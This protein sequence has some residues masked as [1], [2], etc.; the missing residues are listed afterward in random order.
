MGHE[1]SWSFWSHG[2][3]LTVFFFFTVTFFWQS[4]NRARTASQKRHRVNSVENHVRHVMNQVST[5]VVL[6]DGMPASCGTFFF[7]IV[8]EQWGCQRRKKKRTMPTWWYAD[9]KFGPGEAMLPRVSRNA[10]R[11]SSSFKES[12]RWLC[13]VGSE[14][15]APVQSLSKSN[16]FCLSGI[17]N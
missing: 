6:K 7:P 17:P 14:S 10:S 9:V 12:N 16:D 8:L 13:W 1:S 15:A 2:E 4:E 5:L 3:H 11:R